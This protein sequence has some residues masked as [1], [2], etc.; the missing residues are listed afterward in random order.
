MRLKCLAL[1][2]LL[3][4]P[5]ATALASPATSMPPLAVPGLAESHLSPGFWLES[6]SHPDQVVLD[7]AAIEAQNARM[8]AEDPSIHD[9]AALPDRIR[10]AQVREWIEGLST[11]PTVTMYDED[12]QAIEIGRA[13]CRERMLN[14]VDSR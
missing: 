9:L 10:G 7:R 6:L 3:A 11:L 13:S 4:L 2:L 14:K 8:I 12:G 1:G 5:A